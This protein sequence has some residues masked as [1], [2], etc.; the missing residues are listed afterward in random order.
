[1]H[2]D[3]LVQQAIQGLLFQEARFSFQGS[4]LTGWRAWNIHRN[5]VFC[6]ILDLKCGVR[7]LRSEFVIH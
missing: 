4:S 7:M 6:A 1:M 3:A 5:Y 2:S